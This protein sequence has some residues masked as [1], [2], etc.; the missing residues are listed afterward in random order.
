MGSLRRI[1]LRCA[2]LMALVLGVVA[3]GQA[4]ELDRKNLPP[5]QELMGR[6]VAALPD[7]QLRVIGQMQSKQRSGD[8]E[9]VMNM[10]M[11]LDWHAEPPMARYTIRDAFGASLEALTVQWNPGGEAEYFYFKGDP[12]K[13]QPLPNLYDKIQGTDISWIDLS[14]S[15]LWWPYGRTVG[16]EEIKGRNCYIVD[17]P[18]P[19][20]DTNTYA[21]VRLWIDPQ[22]SMLLQVVAYNLQ[23][24]EIGKLEVKSFKKIN[25][26]WMIRD[27]EV[28][29]LLTGH[30][31][32][33]RVKQVE[34]KE[35]RVLSEE[36]ETEEE[37]PPVMPVPATP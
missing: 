27:L 26:V 7:V 21:G 14:L 15:F 1:S 32:S 30:K 23:N 29:N 9:K 35:R 10:E 8:I 17:V 22:I 2:G 12:L 6:V 31:T 5:A 19:T 3:G 13:G 33:L 25:N 18:S 37:V 36:E 20:P 28:Q 11:F 4:A 24:Q 16:V 34:E